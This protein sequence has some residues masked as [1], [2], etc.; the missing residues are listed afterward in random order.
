MFPPL[1][2]E[3]LGLGVA[4]R[5]GR[6]SVGSKT[7]VSVGTTGFGVDED[8]QLHRDLYLYIY[9][10]LFIYLFMYLFIFGLWQT[11]NSVGVGFR[12][13]GPASVPPAAGPPREGRAPAR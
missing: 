8:C 2:F 4:G 1:G 5:R 11:P 12:V 7:H 3:M 6:Q 13:G 9:I 10:Y